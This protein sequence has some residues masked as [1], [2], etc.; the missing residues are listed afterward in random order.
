MKKSNTFKAWPTWLIRL[1]IAAIVAMTAGLIV[2][3]KHHSDKYIAEDNAVDRSQPGTEEPFANIFDWQ[4][5]PSIWGGRNSQAAVVFKD[6]M[7]VFGGKNV[8]DKA[9]NDVWSSSDGIS[10]TQVAENTPWLDRSGHQVQVFQDKIWLMG[11]TSN[12][13]VQLNDVWSSPDGVKWTKETVAAPWAARAD[14]ASVVFDNKLMI[15]GGWNTSLP[16]GGEFTNFNDVWSTTDGINWDKLTEAAAWSK[17]AY[18]SAYIQDKKLFIAGGLTA[19]PVAKFADIYSSTDGINWEKS[20]ELP[21][22]RGAASV[23]RADGRLYLIDGYDQDRVYNYS[24]YSDNGK[25]WLPTEKYGYGPSR[26]FH[27]ALYFKNSV[28][29]IGGT[30][31]DSGQINDLWS[32]SIIGAK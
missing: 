13:G 29:M 5:Q 2:Y 28:W 27:T 15:M 11:G 23:V 6:K 26:A 30:D 18:L 19:I 31:F 1:V 12:L 25:I 10:W 32:T 22:A 9:S 21:E 17:R 20:G 8:S 4:K 14:F 3:Q 7:W 24:L 16:Q